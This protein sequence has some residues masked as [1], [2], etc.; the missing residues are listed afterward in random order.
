MVAFNDMKAL[1]K[2]VAM[3]FQFEPGEGHFLLREIGR[4]GYPIWLSS[5]N[6]EV[7]VGAAEP[8]PAVYLALHSAFIHTLGIEAA[9]GEVESLLG[10]WF[11][12]GK[13]RLVPSRLDL[14]ADVQG[15]IPV[16]SDF[17][18][19]VCRGVRRRMFEQPRELHGFGRRLSGFTF[20]KGDVEAR[21]Y[22]K[23]LEMGSRGQTWPELVW[24][25]A[26]PT[27]PVWRVEF[28]FRRNSLVV[29][30]GLRSIDA[31][32]GA[33]QELWLYGTQWLSVR[34]P[35]AHSKP[36]RWPEAPL[37]AQLRDVTIRSPSSPLVRERIRETDIRRLASGFVGYLSS[38]GL[39]GSDQELDAAVR[40]ALPLARQY[41]SDRGVTF[42]DIVENKRRVHLSLAEASQAARLRAADGRPA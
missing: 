40:R 34:I 16:V 8:F 12:Y 2:G 25:D 18:R 41:L 5:P 6:Y 4:R 39:M 23:T 22:D 29:T 42:A 30:F 36:S 28:Q 17:D 24:A 21:T 26:D 20:G 27:L 32:L 13:V 37:W 7:F 15:W 11:F 33:R 38:I 14:Y 1:A 3:V 31:A 9:V 10:K 19:F 35:T